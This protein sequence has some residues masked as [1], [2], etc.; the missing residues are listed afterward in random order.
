MI[1][2]LTQICPEMRVPAN[3]RLAERL[4]TASLQDIWMHSRLCCISAFLWFD[5][6]LLHFDNALA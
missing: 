5:N 3:E 4:L 1:F 6:R 2:A